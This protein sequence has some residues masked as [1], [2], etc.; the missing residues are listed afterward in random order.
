MIFCGNLQLR[1][2]KRLYQNFSYRVIA[3]IIIMIIGEILNEY[4]TRNVL[5][6]HKRVLFYVRMT[7]MDK[8]ENIL[9]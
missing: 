1:E 5:W 7:I 4:E 6:I 8:Y 9:N 2:L 3:D